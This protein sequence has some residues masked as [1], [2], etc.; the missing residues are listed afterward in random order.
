MSLS[1][2]LTR[3]FRKKQQFHYARI[4]EKQMCMSV[5]RVEQPVNRPDT[6]PVD[7]LD[8]S[9][10]GKVWDGS[11]WL[12]TAQLPDRLSINDMSVHKTDSNACLRIAS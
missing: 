3:C 6:V 4:N 7:Y 10:I 8:I 11:K 1:Y 12:P 5:W 2:W 9:L